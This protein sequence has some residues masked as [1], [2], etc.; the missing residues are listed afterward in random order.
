MRTL[1]EGDPRGLTQ[2]ELTEQM[3]SDPNTVASL[4][5][6]MESSGLVERKPHEQDR[7][8]HRIRLRALGRRKY[9]Q[10][11]V[12]AVALQR[13]VLASLPESKREDFLEQLAFVADTC[14]LAAEASPRRSK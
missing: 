6:R 3:A 12:I 14:R 8:A 7:R 13:E 11:R 1:L 4:L 5:E 9:E 10:I 2:R